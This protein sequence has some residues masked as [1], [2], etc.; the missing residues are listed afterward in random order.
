M[1]IFVSINL[2]REDFF[3]KR[4]R[5]A[6]ELHLDLKNPEVRRKFYKFSLDLLKNHEWKIASARSLR[7]LQKEKNIRRAEEEYTRVLNETLEH[8]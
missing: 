2:G 4:Q 3:D 1:N 6:E 8:K 7:Q 5:I